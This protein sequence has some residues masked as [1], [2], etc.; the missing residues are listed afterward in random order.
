MRMTHP[1]KDIPFPVLFYK[2]SLVDRVWP[3][4]GAFEKRQTRRPAIT[5]RPNGPT[6]GHG[7][8]RPADS[9]HTFH[10]C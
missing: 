6:P 10:A 5:G 3:T 2:K 9:F 1:C 4:C 7:T 8:W